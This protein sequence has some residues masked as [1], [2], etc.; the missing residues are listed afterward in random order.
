MNHY[1]DIE[2]TTSH[3]IRMIGLSAD[4]VYD[5]DTG[6]ST[7]IATTFDEIK[8]YFME[9]V[10][11]GDI[12]CTWNGVA[13]DIR[14]LEA[15]GFP[16][17]EL[18]SKYK[19]VHRDY[20]LIAKML[21]PDEYSHALAAYYKKLTGN[22]L[23]KPK[24]PSWY[25]TVDDET[26][27]AY[28]LKDLSATS[29]VV[30]SLETRMHEGM[31][32]AIKVEHEVRALVSEQAER[33]FSFNKRK[34]EG[35]RICLAEEMK[36]IERTL[37]PDL[38]WVDIPKSSLDH[39]PKKQFLKDGTPSKAIIAYCERYRYAIDKG[40]H[41]YTA[42]HGVD[43]RILKLPLTEPL[44]TKQKL[45]LNKLPLL[46]E[47]LL[48]R[49]WEPTSWNTKKVTVEG[50][51]HYEKTSPRLYNKFTK[52]PCPNLLRVTTIDAGLVARWLMLRSRK[53][54]ILSDK[55]TGWLA[56]LRDDG[57][58]RSDADTLG[59]NT[60]RFTHKGIANI[61]RVTSPFGEVMR[62]LFI[63]RKGLKMTGWD[64]SG[65][66]ARMEAHYIY[67]LDP[68]GALNIIEGSSEK[69]TDIHTRN[70]EALNLVSRDEAK[71]FKYMILYGAKPSRIASQFNVS[72]ATAKKWYDDFFSANW[73]LKAYID[74]LEKEWIVN[75]K[76]YILGLDGRPI[77]TRSQHSLLNAKFQSAGAV[78][79]KHA[80]LIAEKLIGELKE[81]YFDLYSANALIRYHDEEQWEVF[82]S[83]ADEVGRL[84][85]KSIVLAGKYLKL[86]VPLDG[87]YKVGDNWAET[88]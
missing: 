14:V 2:T 82:E 52:E 11:E 6:W 74:S 79:M 12:I 30:A 60:A 51:T 44:V 16:I 85:V 56:S 40:K 81:Q 22:E 1:L 73:A 19:V 69:G 10:N 59:A 7:L 49:G 13:F 38:S 86:N 77:F 35:L 9:F 67:D 37:E 45:T 33:G 28:L 17:K 88:H 46:K 23:F 47:W 5:G 24:D 53:N 63:P 61:P 42:L 31:E 15:E 43:T 78:V 66:E 83:I 76:K 84:G 87:E 57:T 32:H 62:E 72:I 39:P 3:K 75:D 41:G 34:A 64:A 4:R 29:M 36:R 21:E 26:L 80:M 58:L 68:I 55:G 50:R 71:T 18:M 70:M 65:L 54:V 20:M 27:G 48:D 8:E 25:D